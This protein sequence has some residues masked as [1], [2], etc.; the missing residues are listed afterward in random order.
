[1]PKMTIDD[2]VLKDKK[3][4]IRVDFNVPLPEGKVG[5]NTRIVK[6]L[7]TIEKVISEGGIPIIMSHLGRPKGKADPALSLKPVASVVEELLGQK[8]TFLADCIGSKVQKALAKAK[9]GDCFL[10]E[11]LRFYPGEEKND[12]EFA[13]ELSLLGDL[14]LNDA[15][16][17]AHRAHASVVALPQLMDSPAAGYLMDKE[18][19]YLGKI[20][21][22]PKKPFVAVIGGAKI[23]SKIGV[24]NNLLDKVDNM[25]LGG[26]LVFTFYKMMGVEIGDSICDEESLHLAA[27]ILQKSEEQGGKILLPIDLIITD[28]VSE[29]G[30]KRVVFWEEI[31]PRMTGVDIGPGTIQLYTDILTRSKTITFNGPMGVFEID[32]F[33]EGTYEILE[34][35]ISAKANGAT[36]IIGG[37][38]SAAAAKR[39][40]KEEAFSH[41]STGGGASLEFMEGKIL[42]GIAALKDK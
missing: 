20:L 36:T 3:V 16:G 4:L 2:L 13:R 37:G 28:D 24:I 9:P 15:F 29:K 33:G 12:S 30:V 34:S 10:L 17:A 40:F 26:G 6:A 5:D 19:N 21:E 1:M 27:E 7:P 23:S 18:I 14:Y 8:V 25:L 42:P 39:Y 22:V 31:P 41:I 32:A 11:N 35:I 38:D